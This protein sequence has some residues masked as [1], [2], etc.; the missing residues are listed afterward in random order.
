MPVP[1]R[2]VLKPPRE[3]AVAVTDANGAP[4]AGALVEIS[5]VLHAIDEDRTGPDGILHFRL[6]ADAEI[7]TVIALKSGAGFDYWNCGDR[8]AGPQP[9]PAKL[10]LTLS[11]ARS[12][13][14]HAIDSLGQPV[15]GVDVVPWT[16]SKPKQARHANLSGFQSTLERARTDANGI[17]TIDWLPRDFTN[18]ITFLTKSND[19]HLPQP[20]SLDAGP[21]DDVADIE[22]QLLRLTR[23][24]GIVLT[25]DGNP[26][27]GIVLQ[28]EGRGD[29]NHYFRNMAR[30]NAKGDFE[31]RA[32]PEQSYL[33][34]VLDENW[35]ASS[36]TVAQ[37][38]EDQPVDGL[39][40]RLKGGTVL[41]GMATTAD[42][43]VQANATVT[44]VQSA[45]LPAP[46]KSP[47][48]VRWAKTDSQGH[49]HFR[50]GPGT[51]ELFSPGHKTRRP[52]KIDSQ[53]EMVED[54]RGDQ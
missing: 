20:P 32:F 49:Y 25:A 52:L 18:R 11:G 26:A 31:F 19:F 9:P 15:P 1:L 16:V 27:A 46:A 39:E 23:I 37:V 30:T 41:R 36:C 34:S 43:R 14:V 13:R 38:T 7:D 47:D 50:I 42:G 22:M 35:A 10:E 28:A 53:P 33:I 29:S 4:V 6:P 40:F 5:A 24:S 2:I 51:Y 45:G 44:L 8:N 3:L 54:F 21:N 48:L 12:V 17:A